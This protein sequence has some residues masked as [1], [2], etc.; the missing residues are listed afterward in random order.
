MAFIAPTAGCV[1][2]NIAIAL[3][4]FL[5]IHGRRVTTAPSLAVELPSRSRSPSPSRRA[6]HHPQFTIAS[7]IAAHRRCDLGPSPPCSHRPLPMRSLRAIRCHRGAVAPS[8][9]VAVE[10]EPSR[11]PSPSRSRHA[12]PRR[13]GAITP[14]LAVE[15]PSRRPL[16]SPSRS[17]HAVPAVE[18]PLRR[19][20]PSRSRRA[21]PCHQGAA[22]RVY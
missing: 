4:R 9:A 20:L 1:D 15:E 14:S 21:V 10:E 2:I 5:A 8:I 12:V 3:A 7:S 13:R 17:H 11:C 18:E 22:G 19:P 6:L 16:Q